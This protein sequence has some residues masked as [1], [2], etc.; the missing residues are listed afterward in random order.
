MNE[1]GVLVDRTVQYAPEFISNPSYARDLIIADF[2]GDTWEDIVIANTF[3]QEAVYYRNQGN[4]ANGN[5]LGLV[6]E[7]A[8]R[9]PPI[10]TGQSLLCAIWN[11]DIN[12]DGFDDLYLLNYQQSN[13]TAFDY[14]FIND[15]NGVFTNESQSRLGNLRNSAFGTAVEIVD[16]DNDG[17]MDVV[18][19]SALF[20]VSPWNTQG[21]FILYNDGTGNFSNWQHLGPSTQSYMFTVLDL[22]SDG[23]KD[24]VV[25][26]DA[27]DYQLIATNI[28]ADSN[29]TYNQTS[30][31]SSRTGQFGGNIQ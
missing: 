17:D 3:D 9:L 30:I 19:T 11:G 5:W 21:I 25:V 27:T 4:D 16:I 22:N 31:N 10:D 26:D 20:S 18:K 29:I 8:T 1:G 2:D 15:G 13:G 28:V 14:L 24:I 12:G 7:T 23:M 6:D